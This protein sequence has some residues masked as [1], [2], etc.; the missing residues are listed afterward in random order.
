MLN[1]SGIIN[2]CVNLMSSIGIPKQY[3]INFD[4]TESGSVIDSRIY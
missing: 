1:K 2:N 3:Q 4:L